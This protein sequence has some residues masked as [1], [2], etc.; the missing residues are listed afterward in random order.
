[1]FLIIF[2]DSM[3]QGKSRCDVL[4]GITQGWAYPRAID[5]VSLVFVQIW[6]LQGYG[7][8]NIEGSIINVLTNVHFI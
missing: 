8:Y 6:K 1:M 4:N 7:Q 2:Q 3:G 5:I